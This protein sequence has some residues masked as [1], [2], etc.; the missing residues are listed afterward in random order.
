M[1]FDQQNIL[2]IEK[3]IIHNEEVNFIE[4]DIE[5]NDVVKTANID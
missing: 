1:L 5:N 2:F 4:A 3:C